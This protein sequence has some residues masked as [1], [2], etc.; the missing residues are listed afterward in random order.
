MSQLAIYNKRSVGRVVA[1]TAAP[2]HVSSANCRRPACILAHPADG[3]RRSQTTDGD[4]PSIME[5][6]VTRHNNDGLSKRCDCPRRQ[7]LKCD[8]PWHFDFY[9]RKKFRFSLDKIAEDRGEKPPRTK[10]D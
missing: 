10:G 7:W 1:R 2:K 3:A 5:A 6:D 8:H 4:D 9:K